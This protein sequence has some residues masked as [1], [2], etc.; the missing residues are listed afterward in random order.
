MLCQ[1]EDAI[2][3]S[4]MMVIRSNLHLVLRSVSTSSLT[5][6]M[7]SPIFTS[8]G[9]R[10]TFQNTLTQGSLLVAFPCHYIMSLKPFWKY[11]ASH[12]SLLSLVRALALGQVNPSLFPL[13]SV[14]VLAPVER[15]GWEYL[16]VPSCSGARPLMCSSCLD[17]GIFQLFL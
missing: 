14:R 13:S 9:W 6:Y 17:P 2:E 1:S 11:L 10:L 8:S 7:V 12:P 4:T 16:F 3:M 15:W 5:T